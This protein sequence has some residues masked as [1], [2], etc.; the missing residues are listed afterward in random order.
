MKW[1]C[2]WMRNVNL[3]VLSFL[4]IGMSVFADKEL[5]NGLQAQ[6]YK[7]PLTF[8]RNEGQLGQ[9]DSDT[10]Y[11]TRGNGYALY[12]SPQE[13]VMVL[14][15]QSGGKSI[16][17]SHLKI[18]FIGSKND[19]SINGEEELET[20]SNYL[21]G[22]NP[23]QWRTNISN[24]AKV[25]YE[26]LYPGINAVFYGSQEQLEYDFCVAPGAN[27]KDVCLHIEGAQ[28]L[29][30]DE[31]GNL[32]IALDKSEVQMN[33][34]IV[35]QWDNEKKVPVDGQF[36]LLAKN[37]VGFAIG[38]YD[39]S[40]TLIIDPI[41]AYSTFL[42]GSGADGGIGLIGGG[43][44][45]TQN[46][47]GI[48]VDRDGNAYICG[49]TSSKNYPTTPCAI[50]DTFA[51][52]FD[53]C[54]TK[55]N[56]D[57]TKIIFSTYLGGSGFDG[58][59]AIA[60]DCEKN[61]YITGQTSSPNFPGTGF[62]T[63]Q[64]TSTGFQKHVS[65]T[66]GNAFLTKLDPSGKTILY[67]TYCGGFG[68]HGGNPNSVKGDVG[69]GIA[70]DDKGNAY[71][72]GSTSSDTFPV[73]PGA[74]QTTYNGG[75]WDAFIVKVDTKKRGKSS[76][77]YST[78]LGGI[79]EDRAFGIA[80]DSCGNA[81]IT[82]HTDSTNFPV[83]NALQPTYGEGNRDCFLTK[84]NSTGSDLIFST[85]CGSDGNDQAF[86]IALDKCDNIYITGLTNSTPNSNPQN[87]NFPST[88][89]AFQRLP[90]G[91]FLNAFITKFNAEGTAILF[92]TYFGGSNGFTF[93]N[94][95]GLDRFG[96]PCISGQT[97][98][99]NLP[100]KNA[101]Q[102]VYGGGDSDG[103]VAKLSSDLS[104][105]FFSTFLGGS[106]DD[107]A[108]SIAL[109]WRGDVY[110]GGATDST[111]FFTTRGVFQPTYGG[112]P[113]DIFVTKFAFRACPPE[114]L[115][116]FQRRR[117]NRIINILKWDA[118]TKGLSISF[119]EVAT[120]S[121]FTDECII[122][123]VPANCESLR[124]AIG[125][126]AKRKSYTYFVRSVDELSNASDPV[127]VTIRTIKH[128]CFGRR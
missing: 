65:G 97:S 117:K 121:E 44:L 111:N 27:P 8:E 98:A 2:D 70:V 96:N 78:F 40:K 103:F 93:A 3:F 66:L 54:V 26:G 64:P 72:T 113:L 112:G 114:N 7:L 73:T 24:F 128:R 62:A 46:N 95:I 120:N 34:P 68:E 52:G 92:S 51:G 47:M 81:Y 91:D 107:D 79:D 109:D 5:K 13:V 20:K 50:Q 123:I 63:I 15:N 18:Q 77:I 116:G 36:V 122:G 75:I 88:N 60:V 10:K 89:N 118:P 127:K 55:I 22:N 25:S 108:F 71:F 80:I 58:A 106:M 125:P 110:I 11:F 83:K 21:I 119:Y 35:Y 53:A 90:Q 12:F 86:S 6:S 102:P 99:T 38:S 41:I 14:R 37:Y 16:S 57:G 56:C 9:I 61:I 126:L 32:C 48:A 76:L 115:T 49:Q 104:K 82:G 42:G 67:S 33:K 43:G 31:R 23:Q 30:I 1:E 17:F 19:S 124:F 100:T 69:S 84:L 4:M 85:Y 39:P 101:T 28:K 29:E 59:N 74:F 45:G 87:P 105:L 94:S